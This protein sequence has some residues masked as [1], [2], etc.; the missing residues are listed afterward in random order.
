MLESSGFDWVDEGRHYRIRS[1][2]Q[3]G[4]V[5]LHEHAPRQHLVYVA[6]ILDSLG[7]TYRDTAVEEL[8]GGWVRYDLRRAA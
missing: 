8:G 6:S 7:Q 3:G 4:Y 1:S 2:F 5:D